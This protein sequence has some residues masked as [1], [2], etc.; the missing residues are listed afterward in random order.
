MHIHIAEHFVLMG[1][2]CCGNIFITHIENTPP[3]FSILSPGNANLFINR[4]MG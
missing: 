1:S 3:V 2:Y 4:K